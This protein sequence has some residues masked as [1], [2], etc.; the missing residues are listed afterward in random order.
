M[1]K[2]SVILLTLIS[3][4][5]AQDNNMSFGFRINVSETNPI[6]SREPQ[7]LNQVLVI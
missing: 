5:L 4:T 7:I 1:K 3:I 6:S 2:L